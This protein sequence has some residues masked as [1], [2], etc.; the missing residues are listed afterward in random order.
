MDYL[1]FSMVHCTV[2]TQTRSGGINWDLLSETD[3]DAV[4]DVVSGRKHL[5]TEAYILPDMSDPESLGEY[6]AWKEWFRNMIHPDD[7]S[8]IHAACIGFVSIRCLT[9]L[10]LSAGRPQD[11]GEPA[12]DLQYVRLVSLG[13]ER[14]RLMLMSFV[15]FCT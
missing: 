13:L 7:V 12:T 5:R 2:E 4:L 6:E 3:I 9:I 11:P 1:P 10:H 8:Q 14:L 15:L